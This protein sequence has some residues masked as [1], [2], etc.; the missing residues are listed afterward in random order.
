[1]KAKC[2]AHDLRSR[3]ECVMCL[4]PTQIYNENSSQ[5]FDN[6]DGAGDAV[7]SFY[8]YIIQYVQ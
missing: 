5:L 1:M 8:L 7:L 6:Y 2:I 4:L 3:P